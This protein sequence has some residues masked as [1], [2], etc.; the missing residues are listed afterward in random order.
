MPQQQPRALEDTRCAQ[1]ECPIFEG[2]P[3]ECVMVDFEIIQ[4]CSAAC[5]EYHREDYIEMHRSCSEAK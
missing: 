3:I 2:E 4:C 5:V 1:C